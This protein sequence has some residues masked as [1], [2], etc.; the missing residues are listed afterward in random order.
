[1]KQI[2]KF[3]SSFKFHIYPRDL[4]PCSH[5]GT[6]GYKRLTKSSD[7]QSLA[8]PRAE[9][10]SLSTR[11]TG[12]KEAKE[13]IDRTFQN[14]AS[15]S[16]T[17]LA[18]TTQMLGATRTPH[19]LPDCVK[20]FRWRRSPVRFRPSCVSLGVFRQPPFFVWGDGSARD[21]DHVYQ[22]KSDVAPKKN[23]LALLICKIDET[24]SFQLRLQTFP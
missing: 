18:G 6:L 12:H 13:A 11:H 15:S 23:K 16:P 14:R 24:Q 17:E 5:M 7:L 8:C 3:K 9:R 21:V 19:K 4:E 22:R 1:M 10:C 20:V 2:Q